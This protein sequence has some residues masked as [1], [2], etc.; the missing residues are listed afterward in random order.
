M[1]PTQDMI[2]GAHYLTLMVEGDTD[3]RRVFRTVDEVRFAW[4]EGDISLHEPIEYRGAVDLRQNRG[5]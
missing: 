1:M 4:E 2:I 5:R 3:T